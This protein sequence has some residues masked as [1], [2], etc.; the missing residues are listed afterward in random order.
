MGQYVQLFVSQCV[1]NLSF[2]VKPFSSYIT[3][4]V[5]AKNFQYLENEKG[6]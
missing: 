6:F 5:G 3:K 1:I 2:L 4:K